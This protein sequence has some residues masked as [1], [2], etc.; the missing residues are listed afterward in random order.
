MRLV[1]IEKNRYTVYEGKRCIA[2]FELE[3][4]VLLSAEEVEE[5]RV[6]DYKDSA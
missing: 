6:A 5:L 3:N 4:N 2:V 1:L